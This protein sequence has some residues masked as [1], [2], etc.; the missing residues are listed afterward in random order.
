MNLLVNWTLLFATLMI[1]MDSTH[2]WNIG[3]KGRV[4]GPS[5]H[6]TYF[7]TPNNATFPVQ[8]KAYVGKYISGTCQYNAV[9][10]LGTETLKSGDL[11]DI[12]A[13]RLKSIIGTGYN[14]MTIAY[15]Y[16]QIVMETILLLYD[17]VNYVTTNPTTSEVT[18]L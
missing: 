5:I 16:R 1:A 4:N 9:Y 17:G 18:I 14:C 8:A 7:L 13:F 10:D 6:T 12:D 15:T 11:I 2:A 3:S